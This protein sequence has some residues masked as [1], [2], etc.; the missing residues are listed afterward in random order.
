[1]LSIFKGPSRVKL[2][3]KKKVYKLFV[4]NFN[5]IIFM[6]CPK[7]KL[8]EVREGLNLSTY[9]KKRTQLASIY[10]CDFRSKL[11]T[12]NLEK[13]IDSLTRADT[14]NRF[15]GDLLY[16]YRKRNRLLYSRQPVHDVRWTCGRHLNILTSF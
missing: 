10:F 3:I 14:D 8:S 12:V 6:L 4:E 2:L 7:L 11:S 15:T 9:Y 5:V 16:S 13:E 1:M